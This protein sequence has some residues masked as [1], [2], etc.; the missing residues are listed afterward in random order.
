MTDDRDTYAS[1][2]YR[3]DD[4][5]EKDPGESMDVVLDLSPWCAIRWLPGD[6]HAQSDYV[7][8]SSP[9]GFA[10]QAGNAGRTG[11][12]EPRWPTVNGATVVDGSITWAAV[13]NPGTNGLNAISAPSAVSE[14]SGLTI[15][16]V[17]VSESRKIAATYAGGVHG[18]D[19]AAVFTFTL[20]GLTRVARQLVPVRR[21]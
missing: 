20:R 11:S 13:A 1:R 18:M 9:T 12:R 17:A 7:L 6:D 5:P 19:Y 8:P 14:P 10:Y 2:E 16:S 4:T 3:F 15:S 21:R